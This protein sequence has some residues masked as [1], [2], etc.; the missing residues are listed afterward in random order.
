MTERLREF[1]VGGCTARRI[2]DRF[3]RTWA[4]RTVVLR[5]FLDRPGCRIRSLQ[6]TAGAGGTAPEFSTVVVRS[7]PGQDLAEEEGVD[8]GEG[9]AESAHHLLDVLG[10][11]LG[12]RQV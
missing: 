6:L 3:A 12:E 11:L 5:R 8:V 10:S 1:D 2:A 7:A 9:A 4:D